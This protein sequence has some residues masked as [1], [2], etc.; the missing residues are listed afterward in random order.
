[1]G[2]YPRGTPRSGKWLFWVKE[3]DVDEVWARIR[4]ATERGRLGSQSKVATARPNPLAVDPDKRVICVYTYDWKDKT[5]AMRIREELRKLGITQQIPY[6]T[7]EDTLKGKYRA[8]G[9]TRI[10]KYYE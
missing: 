10:S 7:D 5:D 8:K 4:E 1:M 2:R 9:H 6:K 3:D